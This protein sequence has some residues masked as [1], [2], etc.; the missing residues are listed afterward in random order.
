MDFNGHPVLKKI[1]LTK[2]EVNGFSGFLDS[3][4][5]FEKCTF[6]KIV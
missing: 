1:E 3:G 4:N 6:E 2:L 5:R